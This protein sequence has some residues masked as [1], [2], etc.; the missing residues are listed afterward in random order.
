MST[1]PML[2]I[3]TK[4]TSTDEAVKCVPKQHASLILINIQRMN[5][6]AHSNSRWKVKKLS[7][8]VEEKQ[9]K[10]CFVPFSALTVTWLNSNI[11]DAQVNI[12]SHTVT[13]A[14]KNGR[15]EGVLLFSHESIP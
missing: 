4:P 3:D 7:T 6:S 13:R 8:T 2:P 9:E 1:P 11:M 14:D 15:G 5:P 10:H 12:P